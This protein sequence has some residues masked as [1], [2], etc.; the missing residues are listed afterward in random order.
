M[1]SRIVKRPMAAE[2][3][4]TVDSDG[5]EQG[6][7]VAA[8]ERVAAAAGTLECGGAATALDLLIRPRA[9][10]CRRVPSHMN[11]REAVRES[12]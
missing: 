10:R 8:L 3:G 11:V 7:C 1:L 9:K 12:C 2:L 6:D 4:R 5:T